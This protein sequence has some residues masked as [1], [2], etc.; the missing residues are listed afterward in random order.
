M[1]KFICHTC[2]EYQIITA[3]KSIRWHLGKQ[4]D[5]FKEEADGAAVLDSLNV[6]GACPWKV[7]KPVSTE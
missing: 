5:M 3:G 4:M 6:I 7:N 1:G 2:A